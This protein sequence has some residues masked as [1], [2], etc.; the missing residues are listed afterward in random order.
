M[1]PGLTPRQPVGALSQGHSIEFTEQIKEI[2]TAAGMA[3]LELPAHHS[4]MMLLQ[5]SGA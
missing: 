2:E 4:R 1:A 5:I 3:G